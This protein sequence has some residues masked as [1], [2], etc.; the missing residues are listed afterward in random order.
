MEEIPE[1]DERLHRMAPDAYALATLRCGACA[2]LHALWPY[3]RIA[4]IVSGV[5]VGPR[6]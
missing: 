1:I 4:R 3:L 2:N 6:L 5:R